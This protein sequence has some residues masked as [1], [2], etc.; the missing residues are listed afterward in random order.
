MYTLEP[1]ARFARAG[2]SEPKACKNQKHEHKEASWAIVGKLECLSDLSGASYAISTN[3]KAIL[4]HLGAIFDQFWCLTG[5]SGAISGAS[6]G[7]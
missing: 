3:L 2:S 6:T 1:R 4:G 5:K 7:S